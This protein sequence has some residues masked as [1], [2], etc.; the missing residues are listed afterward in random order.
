MRSHFPTLSATLAFA[1]VLSLACASKTV[2]FTGAP[3]Q[4]AATGEM[5]VTLDDNGNVEAK[6]W[7]EHLAPPDRLNPPK[8]NYLVWA[9]STFGRTVLLGQLRVGKKLDASWRGT[10]PFE[11]FRL[12]ITAEDL[13]TPEH[14]SSPYVMASEYLSP[15]KQRFWRF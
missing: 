2:R 13:N 7:L 12:L 11:R 4:P 15:P 5:K 10:V 3:E 14:P 8:Q 6:I 9:Q 1:C